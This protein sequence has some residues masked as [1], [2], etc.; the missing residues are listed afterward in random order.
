M[1]LE[2]GGGGDEKNVK[3]AALGKKKYTSEKKFVPLHR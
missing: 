2:V 1:V 3:K